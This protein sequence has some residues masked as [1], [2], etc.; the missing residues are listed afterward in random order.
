M[1]SAT[2]VRYEALWIIR[3]SGVCMA[4][5]A[6]LSRAL[7]SGTILSFSLLPTAWILVLG[8][9]AVDVVVG[10]LE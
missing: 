3:V 1:R 8:V 6:V 7:S 5:I 4:G 2:G 9:H 10:V